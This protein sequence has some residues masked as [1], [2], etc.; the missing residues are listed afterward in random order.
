M[1][2]TPQGIQQRTQELQSE[3]ARQGER[4]QAMLEACFEAFFERDAQK[5]KLAEGR[6]DEIDQVDVEIERLS[7]ALL[8]DATK[9]GVEMSPLQLRWVL[10]I[11][12]VNNELERIADAAANVAHLSLSS[13]GGAGA[14][15]ETFRVMA[16]SVIGIMRDAHVSLSRADVGLARVVLQSQHAVEAFKDAVLRDAEERIAKGTMTVDLAFLLHEVAAQC[17]L[18]AD[19]CSNI[20]EQVIYLNTGGI[21]RH[22]QD[23]WVD[24][25]GPGTG[26]GTR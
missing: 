17:E 19:H 12:K 5:A 11:V 3:L 6:D 25:P 8:A 14:W 23:K 4:V 2:T 15:P 18:I 20:A 1:P 9:L 7:V 21:V 16:N 22:M 26:A 24:L 10:T 13:R